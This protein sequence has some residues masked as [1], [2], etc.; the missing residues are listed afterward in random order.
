MTFAL[1]FWVLM[2]IWFFFGGVTRARP[3]TLG[4]YGWVGD[5]LLIFVLFAILGIHAFGFVK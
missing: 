1:L 3:G 5:W 4:P 2:I